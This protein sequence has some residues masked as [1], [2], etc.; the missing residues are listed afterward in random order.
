MTNRRARVILVV[1]LGV[2]AAAGPALA[3]NRAL[4]F[5]FEVSASYAWE[6][7]RLS[8]TY[9]HSYSPPYSPNAYQSNASQTLAFE[10]MK[11]R[12]YASGIRFFPTPR[13]GVELLYDAFK[14]NMTGVNSSYKI[15]LKYT[16]RVP[17][18][19]I[20]VEHTFETQNPWPATDGE[21]KETILSLNAVARV[22]I[23]SRLLVKLSGGPSFCA[24]EAKSTSIA[25][26]KFW[27]GGPTVLFRQEYRLGLD[28]GK[29]K[30][31]GFN[32]GGEFQVDL[33]SQTGL[34]FD[35]RYFS[36]REVE[37]A[38]QVITG[39][40]VSETPEELA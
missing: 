19:D 2:A 30:A 6:Q 23:G 14:A 17:P 36:F 22:P 4:Y 26:S 18:A 24:F 13:L 29:V 1:S 15:F 34:A 33:F 7:P 3:T 21:F 25:F 5:K 8:S 40:G 12:G 38:W 11:A 35:V 37:A 9:L 32:V 16:V 39:E 10:G 28:W 20:P 27:L 31:A